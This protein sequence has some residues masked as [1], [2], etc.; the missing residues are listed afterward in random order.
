MTRR[1]PVVRAVVHRVVTV[2]VMDRTVVHRMVHD[3]HA[4]R[5]RHRQYW[6]RQSRNSQSDGNHKLLHGTP[7]LV[8][9]RQA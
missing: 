8:E 4:T 7:L 5:L 2:V 1:R 3:D 9:S 6:R